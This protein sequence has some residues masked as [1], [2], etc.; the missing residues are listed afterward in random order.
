MT[1]PAPLGVLRDEQGPPASARP[2][3]VSER[4]GTP[5][6]TTLVTG[7]FVAILTFDFSLKTLAEFVKIGT[8]FLSCS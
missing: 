8:L 7:V 3:A 5:Y 6:R 2:W 1:L 4:Y